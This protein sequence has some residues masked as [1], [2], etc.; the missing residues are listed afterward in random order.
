MSITDEVK[1]AQ[2][3]LVRKMREAVDEQNYQMIDKW[4]SLARGL[5]DAKTNL[6]RAV[7]NVVSAL[8][9]K[10][11]AGGAMPP[12]RNSMELE[13]TQ[14]DIN[15]NLLRVTE[16]LPYRLVPE[17]SEEFQLVA[18]FPDGARLLATRI[19]HQYNRLNQRG[20][21]GEFYRKNHIKP[22]DK[23]LWEKIEDRKYRIS[24]P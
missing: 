6:E 14:G 13:V 15:Q 11:A 22:G 4:N 3:A 1:A 10:T 7:A 18:T 12:D 20:P 5:A 2:E 23:I 19:D 17:D 9:G 21:I 8:N 16:L 24:K